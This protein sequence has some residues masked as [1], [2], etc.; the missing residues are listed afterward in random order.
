[1]TIIEILKKI[2]DSRIFTAFYEGNFEKGRTV[3]KERTET[4]NNE[5]QPSSTSTFKKSLTEQIQSGN[6][7]ILLKWIREENLEK[8]NFIF[9]DNPE[10][11][12]WISAQNFDWLP[13]IP[14]EI[15]D[16]INQQC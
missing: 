14:P 5:Q 15:M 12:R 1:M 11:C 13:D 2:E 6:G 9:S 4:N 10:L 3:K 16:I 7:R 8:L